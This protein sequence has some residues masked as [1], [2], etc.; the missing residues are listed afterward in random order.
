VAIFTAPTAVDMAQLK[1]SV[2]R[3]DAVAERGS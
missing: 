3:C 1:T 2:R